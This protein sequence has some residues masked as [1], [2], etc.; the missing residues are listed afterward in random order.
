MLVVLW[1][2]PP[3]VEAESCD[4]FAFTAL[5]TQFER[6]WHPVKTSHLGL[7]LAFRIILAFMFIAI[8]GKARAQ[9]AQEKQG[10]SPA[11]QDGLT[12]QAARKIEFST[13][14]GTW[15]SLDVSA[16]AARLCLI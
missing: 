4:V 2:L 12:L 13:D 11:K 9:S 8:P 14:E 5:R 6:R 15:I 16:T 3:K 10:A 7:R 1:T